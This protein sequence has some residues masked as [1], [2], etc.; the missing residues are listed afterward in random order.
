VARP[1]KF[2]ESGTADWWIAS[3]PSDEYYYDVDAA[4]SEYNL[5]NYEESCLQAIVDSDSSQTVKFYCPLGD[6]LRQKVSSEQSGPSISLGTPA[7][8]RPKRT[9]RSERSFG[10][11]PKGQ[12]QDACA[13]APRTTR[14]GVLGDYLQ[15]YIDSTL[16][17]QPADPRGEAVPALCRGGGVLGALLDSQPVLVRQFRK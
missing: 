5:G 1:L 2:T 3:G 14:D 6:G 17:D 12:A 9:G 16:K 10:L 15:F 7:L 13:R 8:P 4:Q 11:V